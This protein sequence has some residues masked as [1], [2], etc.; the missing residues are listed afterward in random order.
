MDRYDEFHRRTEALADR[1]RAEGFNVAT[2]HYDGGH[3]AHEFPSGRHYVTIHLGPGKQ[4]GLQL[5][6]RNPGDRWSSYSGLQADTYEAL[7]ASLAHH[8]RTL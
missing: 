6:D 2:K 8:A 7:A 1:L 5:N 4:I 3:E